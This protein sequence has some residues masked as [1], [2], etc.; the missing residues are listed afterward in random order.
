MLR[1]HSRAPVATAQQESLAPERSGRSARCFQHTLGTDIGPLGGSRPRTKA[2]C[3]RLAGPSQKAPARARKA[4]FAGGPELRGKK[5]PPRDAKCMV[6]SQARQAAALARSRM[7]PEKA[8]SP[9]LRLS[10]R[11]MYRNHSRCRQSSP[12]MARL[13]RSGQGVGRCI[14]SALDRGIEPGH[15]RQKG[16]VQEG[17][18]ARCLHLAKHW[19]C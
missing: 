13:S 15:Q 14:G 16:R 8:H 1:G 10:V 17:P 9:E 3:R 18:E 11:G 12:E 19:H 7:A 4:L 5:P 6:R 2:Q